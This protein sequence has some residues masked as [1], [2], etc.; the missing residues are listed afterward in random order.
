MLKT[1]FITTLSFLAVAGLAT[2]G[3]VNAGNANAALLQ[4]QAGGVAVNGGFIAVGTTGAAEASLSD[5]GLAKDAL[6]ADFTQFGPSTEFATPGVGNNAGFF[7]LAA[8]GAGGDAPFNGNN[9]FLI[10][11]DGASLADS[12]WLFI[13][14]SDTNFGPDLPLFAASVNLGTDTAL[15]GG[16]SGAN[17]INGGDAFQMAAVGGI[18]PEPGVSILALFSAG[19]LVLRRRRK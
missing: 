18:V 5:A 7:S 8:N 15:L 12:N 2:A 10:G 17:T 6:L 3:T 13:V 14:R 16:I 11:G 19:L 1:V 4:V 9:V